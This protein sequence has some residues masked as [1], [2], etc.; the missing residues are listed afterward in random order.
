MRTLHG[1]AR[2]RAACAR[3]AC[4]VRW[5]W[6]ETGP[7]LPRQSATLPISRRPRIHGTTRQ[8]VGLPGYRIVAR[9]PGRRRVG[10]VS[11]V[12]PPH[13]ASGAARRGMAARGPPVVSPVNA[14]TGS[15]CREVSSGSSTRASDERLQPTGP[16]LVLAG[17]GV[18]YI[19]GKESR[20]ASSLGGTCDEPPRGVSEY[21]L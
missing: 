16:R 20:E 12:R 7:R 3:T 9:A 4:T 11:A 14:R 8:T 19:S 15:P 10:A 21:I 5:G 18:V 1:E 17:C 2:R 13:D 6:L